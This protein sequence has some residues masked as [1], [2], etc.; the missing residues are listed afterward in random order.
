MRYVP[1]GRIT[2]IHG[3]KGEVRFWYYNEV[4]ETLLHYTSL[5]AFVEGSEV[6]LKP[7]HVRFQKG[8]FYI[9]F[10]GL[11]STEEVL[12]LVSKELHVKEEGLPGL[13]DDEYYDFQLIGLEVI[14][15]L[16]TN[17]GRVEEVMH[18]RDQD[19]LVV[20]GKDEVL[21]PMSDQFI[22]SIDLPA[23]LIMVREEDLLS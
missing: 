15:E 21:I 5:V 17:I 4:K 2:G 22:L 6:V 1:V 10:A 9:T 20:A 16:G 18:L 14:N 3:V 13:A 23:S 12:F 7:S 11:T 19:I 8:I